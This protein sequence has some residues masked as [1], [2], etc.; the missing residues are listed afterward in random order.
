MCG[1]FWAKFE[2]KW[3][4]MIQDVTFQRII[5][6]HV[7]SNGL[8]GPPEQETNMTKDKTTLVGR[9]AHGPHYLKS[10]TW[11]LLI[12]CLAQLSAAHPVAPSYKYKG[13][14]CKW[15]NIHHNTTHLS[16][17]GACCLHPR[18]FRQPRRCRRLGGE[19][20]G[21][22]GSARFV[23]TL[24]RLYLDGC[25]FGCKCSWLPYLELE[26]RCKLFLLPYI[27]WVCA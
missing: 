15:D 7:S 26:F 5:E 24:L 20:G 22:R 18:C 19:W 2:A 14:G 16:S 12:G 21:V 4:G 3:C 11:R 10:S 8:E 9:P 1:W 23:G 13:R 25:L 6:W 17:F 27:S